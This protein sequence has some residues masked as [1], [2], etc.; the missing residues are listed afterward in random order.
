M[1]DGPLDHINGD[2]LDN[3][4][5][6]LRRASPAQNS[7][8]TRGHPGSKSGLKGAH[9]HA[10][11]GRWTSQIRSGGKRHHLG[12]FDNKEDAARAYR[13]AAERLN[14]EFARVA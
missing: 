12:V 4:I 1:P 14:G 2:K 6:N 5:A 13:E 9:W 7:A 8:N 11:R 3:R 10:R